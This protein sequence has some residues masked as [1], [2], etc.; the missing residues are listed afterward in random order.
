MWH[1]FCS[2]TSLSSKKGCVDKVVTSVFC[3]QTSKYKW[4]QIELCRL[5]AMSCMCLSALLR[6]LIGWRQYLSSRTLFLFVLCVMRS[7]IHPNHAPDHS[8]LAVGSLWR[9]PDTDLS[10]A[11]VLSSQVLLQC[12]CLREEFLFAWEETPS[13]HACL[14]PYVV[15]DRQES[16]CKL[17]SFVK[18]LLFPQLGMWYLFRDICL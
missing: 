14:F 4:G 5:L 8:S 11:P 12:S 15:V 17:L 1:T 2:G 18:F 3:T 16:K 7:P 13:K 6:A 10:R 9:K